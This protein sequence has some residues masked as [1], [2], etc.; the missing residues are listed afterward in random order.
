MTSNSQAR[1]R[2]R[3]IAVVVTQAWHS[4]ADAIQDHQDDG[5]LIPCTTDPG[6][7]QD[8]ERLPSSLAGR[9]QRAQHLD[10]LAELC[11]ACPALQPCRRYT[12]LAA[13]HGVPVPVPP[14]Q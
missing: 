6:L 1:I 11:L 14:P 10:R 9:R 3:D 2:K 5:H 13:T 12:S 7:F 4:L 8:W